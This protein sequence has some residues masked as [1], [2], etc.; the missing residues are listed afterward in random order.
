MEAGK[1]VLEHV[2]F[3]LRD[4]F[5]NVVALMKPM[6]AK[7]TVT[8]NIKIGKDVPENALGDGMRLKQVAFNLIGNAIKFTSN[9]SISVTVDVVVSDSMSSASNTFGLLI[10]I[11]DTGIGMSTETVA[12]L[13]EPFTQADT[14]TTR[15]Y[16]GTGLGL[17]IS[18]GIVA[19][20]GGKIEVE[21]ELGVAT[22]FKVYVQLSNLSNSHRA[23]ALNGP[24]VNQADAGSITSKVDY[25]SSRVL[26]AEDNLVNQVIVE[27]VLAKFGIKDVILAET[28]QQALDIFL[29]HPPAFFDFI[30]MEYVYIRY[31]SNISCMMPVMDGFEATQKIRQYELESNII[32]TPIVALTASAMNVCITTKILLNIQSDVEKCLAAG[33]DIHCAK[34]FSHS[35]LAEIIRIFGKAK[36]I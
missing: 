14:S 30:L 27:R 3:R 34:P 36:E 17:S 31:K 9:G 26:V 23:S 5:E 22:T 11:K 29:S 25:S 32:K 33:M 28:G 20:M 12:K 24:L 1:I 2:Q 35:E 8:M 16:G 19:L 10:I 21:S 4:V 18:R 7:Q 6:A 15:V 13:F